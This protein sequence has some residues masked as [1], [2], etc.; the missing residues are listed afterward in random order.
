[1]G[2]HR[3]IPMRIARKTEA[4]DGVFLGHQ[5]RL[6]AI[7]YIAGLIGMMIGEFM[8]DALQAGSVQLVEKTVGIA[9]SG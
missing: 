2:R 8:I 9:D 3:H 6:F 1:M 7:F 5:Y 4:L